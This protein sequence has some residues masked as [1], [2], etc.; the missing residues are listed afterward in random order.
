[1]KGHIRRRGKKSWAVIVPLG[2][3]PVTGNKRDKWHSVKGTRSD[4]ER[5]RAELITALYEG[6]YQEPSKRS[7]ADELEDWLTHV[8]PNV[9]TNTFE[10]Y[11][12]IARKHLIPSLGSHALVKLTPQHIEAYYA[13]ALVSGRHRRK[14]DEPP[15]GLSAMTV[16]HHHR[17]L[18]QALKRAVRLRTIQ[19]NPCDVVVSPRA[20]QREM[21]ILTKADTGRLLKAAAG[22]SIYMPILI[23]VTTGMRRGEILGLRW[24]DVDL[25]TRT[26]SVTRTLEQTKDGLSFKPPKTTRSRRAISLPALTVEALRRHKVHLA[27]A[28]LRLGPAFEDHDLVCPRFDGAPRNP[29]ELSKK[30]RRLTDKLGFNVRFHDLRHTHISHLLAEGVHP[31]VASERAG[32]ASVGITLDVYSHVI[33]GLQEDAANRIDAALRPHLERG[34]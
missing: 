29:R 27:K 13:E 19:Y 7:V 34:D 17:I 23:A 3:D 12:E 6:T 15:K 10:R 11:A 28:R 9:A 20:E 26:L 4:A 5:K 25:D 18:S 33:P 21:N 30:V 2:R 14:D 22:R 1:M 8:K 31:K 16:K 24:C 32:H